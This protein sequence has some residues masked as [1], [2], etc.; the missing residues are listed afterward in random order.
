MGM[1]PKLPTLRDSLYAGAPYAASWIPIRHAGGPTMDLAQLEG[2]VAVAR[3]RSFTEAA[4]ELGITQ[5]G[6][7]RQV[8][9]LEREV[10]V[11]LLTRGRNAVSLTPAGERFRVYA[12]DALERRRRIVQ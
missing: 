8:Q 7:S 5:P 3:Q 4:R 9:K 1:K 6:V 2:F 11:T 12:E 10:G